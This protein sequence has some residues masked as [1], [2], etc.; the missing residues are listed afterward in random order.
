MGSDAELARGLDHQVDL[1][2]AVDHHD[3]R[4]AE[5]LRQQ[6][7]LDVGAVLVAV[8]HD[9]RVGRVEQRERHQQLGLAAGLEAHAQGGSVADHLLHHLPLLVHLDRVDAAV[10]APIRVLGDRGAEGAREALDAARQDVGEA[11]QQRRAQ[12][13]ALEVLHQLEQ[14]DAGAARPR[15][16]SPPR[17]PCC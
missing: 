6:R 17:G 12:A 1:V 10:A 8:A 15:A 13:P 16:A 2:E 5:A 14:V 9:Q 11:D 7:Q 3:R 4:A